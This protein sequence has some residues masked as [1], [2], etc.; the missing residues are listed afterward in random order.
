MFLSLPLTVAPGRLPDEIIEKRIT[1]GQDP[2]E[3]EEVICEVLMNCIG[4]DYPVGACASTACLSCHRLACPHCL[5]ATGSSI[6]QGSTILI[7]IPCF[8]AGRATRAANEQ[9]QCDVL[10]PWC[11]H[12]TPIGRCSGCSRRLCNLC[13]SLVPDR[14]LCYRCLV[15]LAPPSDV[16]H[17]VANRI[18]IAREFALEEQEESSIGPDAN[19]PEP[20]AEWTR[21]V[22]PRTADTQ[23]NSSDSSSE[24][25]RVETTPFIESDTTTVGASLAVLLPSM[26]TPR[27]PPPIWMQPTECV[28]KIACYAQAPC[29]AVARCFIC[30]APSCSWCLFRQLQHEPPLE[31][32]FRCFYARTTTPENAARLISWYSVPPHLAASLT[33]GAAAATEEQARLTE[34]SLGHQARLNSLHSVEEDDF[35]DPRPDYDPTAGS[36]ERNCP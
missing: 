14:Q 8:Y 31:A 25:M 19:I 3:L 35:V 1:C 10:M 6:G 2:V 16:E 15:L 22:K 7:C 33:Q 23:G 18:D 28:I 26:G 21:E 29:R 20:D 24:E 13:C 30:W 12:A 32:C 27:R 17:E 5:I 36:S 4:P 9:P 34:Y 11:S